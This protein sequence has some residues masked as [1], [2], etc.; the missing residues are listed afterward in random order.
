MLSLVC[1]GRE[2]NV[3][4]ICFSSYSCLL[5]D[6]DVNGY[7]VE[8]TLSSALT[9][10]TILKAALGSKHSLLLTNKGLLSLGCNDHGQLGRNVGMENGDGNTAQLGELLGVFGCVSDVNVVIGSLWLYE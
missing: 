2:N 7:L 10:C 9:G 5:T 6:P 8:P 1:S 4:L 3:K